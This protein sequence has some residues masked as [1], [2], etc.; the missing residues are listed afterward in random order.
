MVHIFVGGHASVEAHR[1]IVD[2]RQVDQ[3][4]GVQAHVAVHING[5]HV[6]HTLCGVHGVIHV[7][8][9]HTAQ[10][11]LEAGR[12][13]AR[14]GCEG[15]L[16]CACQARGRVLS[17]TTDGGDRLHAGS[18]TRDFNATRLQAAQDEV[19]GC[20]Q[21]LQNGTKVDIVKRVGQGHRQF[22][23]QTTLVGDGGIGGDRRNGRELFDVCDAVFALGRAEARTQSAVVV[24]DRCPGH[25]HG[26]GGYQW[27]LRIGRGHSGARQEGR[28]GIERQC[29]SAGAFR[30]TS[31]CGEACASTTH[32][33]DLTTGVDTVD[34]NLL[35]RINIQRCGSDGEIGS[36]AVQRTAQ[37]GQRQWWAEESQVGPSSRIRQ[38]T[39]SYKT[40][41]VSDRLNLATRV[42]TVDEDSLTC[43][44]IVIGCG[45]CEGVG[46][47]G[48]SGSH[49]GH[50]DG[51]TGQMGGVIKRQVAVRRQR[52]QLT[53]G[54]K[55][56]CV[57][58]FGDNRTRVQTVYINALPHLHQRLG[59]G[60]GKSGGIGRCSLCI[61]HRHG[62][63]A[64]TGKSVGVGVVVLDRAHH[65]LEVLFGATT[66][67]R[68]GE[69]Q[70]GGAGQLLG[71]CSIARD[72]DA[73]NRTGGR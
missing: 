2:T 60:C 66:D 56:H 4:L 21:V 43:Q 45:C 55:V 25:Q 27:T 50:C 8:I 28:G 12:V 37:G 20:L 73:R 39:V 38:I 34:K 49:N 18:V 10:S 24:D 62:H 42:F 31:I 64:V 26:D 68:A 5:R 35:V 67:N 36:G 63:R 71:A 3:G 30:Q 44:D 59:L 22:A 11:D 14:S 58:H 13:R 1:A 33:L 54:H 32:R 53:A 41:T 9:A 47:T 57:A 65:G 69:G 17:D 61:N 70:A 16:G 51:R 48:Q 52:R 7:A 46:S 6:D 40:R 72:I 29:R 15:E 23:Q 19:A